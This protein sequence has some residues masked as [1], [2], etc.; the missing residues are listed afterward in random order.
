VVAKKV[1]VI[2]GASDGIGAAAARALAGH[3]H[4]VVLVGRSPQ[5][6]ARIAGELHAD[7]YVA[8]FADLGAVR[9]LATKLQADHPRIDV[10]ANNAGGVFGSPRAL[11]P[12]G[13]EITFQVN[14]L[15]PFLLTRLLLDRLLEANATVINTSSS[16]NRMGRVDLD[17]LD[18]ERK[19]RAVNA[20]T[21]AK[22]AQ[23]L[24]TRELDRRYGP[25]GLA[26]VTFDP[27]NISSNFAR[28]PDSAL[29]WIHRVPL[30]EQLV[31]HSPERGADTLVHLAEG[32]PGADFPT[33]EYF[34]KRKVARANKQA[35][36]A[37]LA[38]KLWDK[39]EA[40]IR[41]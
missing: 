34:T 30:V 9:E 18:G 33:G 7:S 17:N 27:G 38:A 11:T 31:L 2:T 8:D 25:R 35:Y 28:D 6:T 20:Y 5:K 1:V 10:L 22:L 4:E 13:H 39:S 14:Y 40:M 37:D 3:G 21:N 23:I 16:G 15:A 24:F 29:R 32:S 12:D 19:F 26:S 36:D 41:S